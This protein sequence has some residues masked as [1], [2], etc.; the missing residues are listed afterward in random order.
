MERRSLFCN[1][2]H[3]LDEKLKDITGKLQRTHPHRGPAAPGDRIF[4]PVIALLRKG[5]SGRK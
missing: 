2:S 4:A 1:W 5:I 3:E